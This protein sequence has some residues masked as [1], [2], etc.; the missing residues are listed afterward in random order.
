M[1]TVYYIPDDGR[2]VASCAD[3]RDLTAAPVSYHV[4]EAHRLTLCERCAEGRRLADWTGRP[5]V[6][7][8]WRERA[9]G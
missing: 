7:G 8:Q 3:C 5:Y 2:G 9:A 6:P 4:G 1:E